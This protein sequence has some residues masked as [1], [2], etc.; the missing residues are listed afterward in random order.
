MNWE[1]VGA[2]GEIVGAIAVVVTLIYLAVQMR[3]NTAAINR[4]ATQSILQGRAESAALMASDKEISALM[5]KGADDPDSLTSEEWQRFFF[6]VSS[7]I[8]PIELAFFDYEEGRMAEEM[9]IGQTHTL[10]YWFSRPG[11]QRWLNE[12]GQTLNPAFRN[13]IEK[14]IEDSEH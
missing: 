3:V 8:R 9:W 1:A 4:T 6:L 5:F 14:I 13:C 12:Y 10:I 11:W 7:S 2:V